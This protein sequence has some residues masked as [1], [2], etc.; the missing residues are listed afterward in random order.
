VNDLKTIETKLYKFNTGFYCGVLMPKAVMVKVAKLQAKYSREVRGL[1]NEYKDQLFSSDFTLVSEMDGDKIK[2][3]KIVTYVDDQ[4]DYWI[5]SRIKKFELARP[6][7][8]DVVYRV[9]DYEHAKEVAEAVLDD[10]IGGE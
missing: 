10:M 6:M 5:D 8:V 2:R 1:L 4:S 9:R 7:A 3:Q